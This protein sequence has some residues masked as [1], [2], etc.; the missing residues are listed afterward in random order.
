[1]IVAVMNVCLGGTF[2]VLHKGHRALLLKALRTAGENGYLFIGV[3]SDEFAQRKGDVV[4]YQKR[5]KSIE[6]FIR[7]QR[8]S[9]QVSIQPLSDPYGP[10]I[11]GVFD[12]IVVSAE[13]RSAAEQINQRRKQHGK[14]PLEIIVV[15]FVLADDNKP[16]SST[17][18][19]NREIDENGA[20][21]G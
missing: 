6:Q 12:A 17:R 14:E 2:Q 15:P 3:T 11:D 13:T 10:A 7:E 20:V 19:R 9:T 18:I 4:P 21:L 1:M 8:V 5:K 16:I